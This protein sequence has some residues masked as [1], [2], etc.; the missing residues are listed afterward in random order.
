MY[1]DSPQG[2]QRV[3]YHLLWLGPFMADIGGQYCNGIQDFINYT[4]S[5]PRNISGGGIRRTCKRCKNKKFLFP[6]VVTMY[7]LQKRFMK[8]YMCWYAY[9]EPYVPHD[10]MVEMMVGSTFSSSNVHGV[11]DD[12]N[13]PYKNIVIDAIRMN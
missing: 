6:N 11:V 1:R 13:N 10:I 7:L 5:N 3:N 4:L 12:N 9:G 2:L 8:K